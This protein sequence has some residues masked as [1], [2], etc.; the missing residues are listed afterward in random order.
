MARIKILHVVTALQIFAYVTLACRRE[1]QHQEPKS[2][3]TMPMNDLRLHAMLTPKQVDGV[4]EKSLP[5]Q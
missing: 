4:I 3:I 1:E 5:G 2:N